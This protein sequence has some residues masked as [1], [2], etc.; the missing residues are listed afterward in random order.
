M[1]Y[2][3]SDLLVCFL[4]CGHQEFFVRSVEKD[5]YGIGHNNPI[6]LLLDGHTSRWSYKGLM[7]LIN[8][9]I[10][11][12]FIGSHTSAWAQP[13][14]CGLNGLY[15]SEYG[16]AVQMWRGKFPFMSYDRVAF[17]WCCARAIMQVQLRLA[18]DLASWNA[19]KKV[20]ADAGIEGI[21]GEPKG[22][23]GNC[24]TRMYCRTGWWPLRRDSELWSKVISQFDVSVK[25]DSET[26]DLTKE[27]GPEVRIRQVVL[28]A[29]RDS[30]LNKAKDIK[31]EY[32]KR[33]KRRKTSVPVTV[34]G[35]GFTKGEDLPG[36]CIGQ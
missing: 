26:L 8:A 33:N 23:Q 35:K 11:P 18:G 19:K 24:V 31:T 30:F 16:K 7:T 22:K 1:Y 5:G 12:Y 34:M 36:G 32:D 25:G 4:T 29:F 27:L 20:F 14:D 13:N 6:I 9:G 2:H 3:L 10:Y 21:E 15:K 17:N 28:D